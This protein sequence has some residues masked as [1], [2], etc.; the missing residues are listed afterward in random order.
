MSIVPYTAGALIPA[1]RNFL[2]EPAVAKAIARDTAEAIK[3][4]SSKDPSGKIMSRAAQKAGIPMPRKNTKM[5]QNNSVLD[6]SGS[7][8]TPTYV[9][10][11]SA[12]YPVGYNGE[13]TRRKRGMRRG[14]RVPRNVVSSYSDKITTCFR[15]SPAITNTILNGAGYA[16]SLGVQSNF[17]AAGQGPISAFLTQ[18]SALGALYREFRLLKL[19]IDWVPRVGSTSAGEVAIAIDRDPRAGLASQAVIVRRNPFLQTDIKVPAALEWTPTD[20]KD[21]EWRYCFNTTVVNTRPE[22]H[23][24]FGVLLIA[25]NNDLAN[26]AIIGDL[27]INAWA[28]FAI[29]H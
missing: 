21:R 10:S 24:S 25:S 19:T 27:F 6:Y 1:I 26:G 5:L 15:A 12:A 4:V 2:L 18:W 17:L 29:P 20:S 3:A 11:N 13:P 23:L 7:S 9:R 16:Y 22:E 28:E 8:S 14:S